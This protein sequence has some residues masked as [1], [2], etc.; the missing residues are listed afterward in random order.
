MLILLAF[1]VKHIFS[2]RFSWISTIQIPYNSWNF[3]EVVLKDFLGFLFALGPGWSIKPVVV[4]NSSKIDVRGKPLNTKLET[5][6]FFLKLVATVDWIFLMGR[7]ICRYTPAVFFLNIFH[8][9][10]VIGCLLFAKKIETGC[11][12]EKSYNKYM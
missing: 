8:G 9:E 12:L 1:L 4:E 10:K 2:E 6:L 11:I 7:K 5:A 3:Q